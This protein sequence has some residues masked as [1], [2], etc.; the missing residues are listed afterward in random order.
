MVKKI[1]VI[2]TGY[3]GIVSGAGISDFGNKVTCV[4]ILEQKIQLLKNGIIP[5]YEPGLDELVE[6][7]VKAN[8]LDFS[9]QVSETIQKSD[10]IF[11]AVGTP[12]AENGHAYLNAI[13]ARGF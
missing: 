5:I 4:D 1:A 10:I 13:K 3:V 11:I 6:R 12:Q 8:R 7:N 9:I 2:G